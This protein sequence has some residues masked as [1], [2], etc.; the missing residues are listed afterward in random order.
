MTWSFHLRLACGARSESPRLSV[1]DAYA[2]V[3][4]DAPEWPGHL[5]CSCARGTRAVVCEFVWIVEVCVS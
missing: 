4:G 2:L 1:G 3:G 5:W